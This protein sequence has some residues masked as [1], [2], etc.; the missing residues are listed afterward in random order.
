MNPWRIPPQVWP[1]YIALVL[2]VVGILA[3][4]AWCNARPY[5]RQGIENA[6]ILAAKEARLARLA[7]KDGAK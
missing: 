1:Q 4:F 3:F 5:E 2:G 7:R 6:R